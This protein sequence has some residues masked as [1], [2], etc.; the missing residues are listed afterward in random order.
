VKRAVNVPTADANI[1]NSLTMALAVAKRRNRVNKTNPVSAMSSTSP[2]SNQLQQPP[3]PKE[4][5]RESGTSVHNMINHA[6]AC[7]SNQE[8]QPTMNVGV[9]L[10]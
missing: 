3:P 1:S 8:Q 6:I 4:K 9:C 7:K 2:S 10:P 5:E